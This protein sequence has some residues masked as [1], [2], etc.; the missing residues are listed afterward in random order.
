[1]LL[2]SVPRISDVTARTLLAQLPELGII[3]RHQ[4]AA[5]VGIAPINRNSGLMRG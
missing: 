5:L 4:I 3:G 1:M 2:K